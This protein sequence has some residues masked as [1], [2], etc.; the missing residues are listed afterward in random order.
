MK[1]GEDLVNQLN[2]AVCQSTHFLR[3]MGQIAQ[4]VRCWVRKSDFLKE[5]QYLLQFSFLL[6]RRVVGRHV[7]EDRK[8]AKELAAVITGRAFVASRGALGRDG[9]FR[10]HHVGHGAPPLFIEIAAVVISGSATSFGNF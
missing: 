8:G 9:L 1:S 3:M 10:S 2:C 5:L 6:P 4:G 7:V